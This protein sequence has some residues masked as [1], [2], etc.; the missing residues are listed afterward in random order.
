MGSVAHRSYRS[1]HFGPC[2]FHGQAHRYSFFRGGGLGGRP[3]TPYDTPLGGRPSGARPGRAKR[4][5]ERQAQRWEEVRHF[6]ELDSDDN[7]DNDG[8]GAGLGGRF[9][10]DALRF[11]GA[12]LGPNIRRRRSH[13]P[14]D[15]SESSD[16]VAEQRDE[17]SSRALQLALR[18][19]EEM[20]VQKALERIRRSQVLGKA[21]VKLTQPEIDALERKRRLD[22]AQGKSRGPP[23]KSSDRRRSSGRP[24]SAEKPAQL[25][26]TRRNA[27]SSSG[28]FALTE[29]EDE[30][31]PAAAVTPAGMMVRGA[32]GTPIYA[33]NGYY[34]PP[35][36]LAYGTSSRPGSRS[37]SAHS[38]QQQ[39]TPPLPPALQRAQKKR[40]SSVPERAMPSPTSGTPASHAPPS[41]RVLPNDPGWIPR[42]RS[43]S[44]NQP[45]AIDPF[46]YQTYSPPL[47]QIP[48]QYG[49]GRRIVSGPAGV[50]YPAIR[51]A[52]PATRPY[53]ASA[54]SSLL[55]RRRQQSQAVH[56][57]DSGSGEEEEEDSD[58]S[59][60]DDEA[61][62]DDEHGVHVDVIPHGQGYD[63]SF[64]PAGIGGGRHRSGRR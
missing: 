30:S 4:E 38:L 60:D 16:E 10:S 54:D 20:L 63:V 15:G 37:A 41:S 24:G 32:D 57:V 2:I 17:S 58:D 12:D 31:G 26:S 44:T 5:W 19:K 13:Y 51:Q 21:N 29:A 49:Y 39:L 53:A 42:P 64:T 9:V 40:Y 6:E 3:R 47:P 48:P 62:D 43:E 28:R 25:E 61:G 14:N 56:E 7:D 34:P 23:G 33:P 27:S 59:E 50:R 22:Q 36:A 11:T 35:A 1:K 18:D 55:L 8:H 46:Q 52:A 45:H